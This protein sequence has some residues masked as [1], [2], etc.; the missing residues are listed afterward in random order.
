[1]RLRVVG[2]FLCFFVGN[3]IPFGMHVSECHDLQRI[4]LIRQPV[5]RHESVLSFAHARAMRTNAHAVFFVTFLS[6]R[7]VPLRIGT[8]GVARRGRIGA[9]RSHEWLDR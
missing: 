5:P 7:T 3:R 8:S 4:N 2:H 1:M 9:G 6:P